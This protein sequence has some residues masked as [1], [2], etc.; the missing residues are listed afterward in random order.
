MEKKQK[1]LIS[2]LLLVVGVIF[3]LIAGGI[4]VTTAWEYLPLF[5]KQLALL[6]VAGV[7]FGGSYGLSKNEKLGWI[8]D[9]LFHLGNAFIGFFIIAIMGGVVQNGLVGN[10]FKVFAASGAMAIPVGVKM[11]NNKSPFDYVA[12]SILVDSML[13]SGCVA[14]KTTYGIYL[15]LLAAF[16][17]TLTVVDCMAQ[18]RKTWENSF[19]ICV[20]VVNLVHTIGFALLSAVYVLGVGWESIVAIIL[21]ATT[22]LTTGLSWMVRKNVAFRIW[23]S[24]TLMY[25]MFATMFTFVNLM[26]WN[27]CQ[28]GELVIATVFAT[29]LMVALRR[30]EMI[31]ITIA[32]AVL[33]PYG[34]LLCYFFDAWSWWDGADATWT[35]MYNPYSVIIGVGILALYI[36]MYGLEDMLVNWKESRLLTF[37]G[38]QMLNGIV[39][40]TCS[41]ATDFWGMAFFLLVTVDWLLVAMLFKNKIARN[42][43]NTFAM[44][45]FILAIMNQPFV[46]VKDN[47]LVEW[48]CF[49]FGIMI[50]LFRYIWYDKKDK[51]SMV[52]FVATCLILITLLLHNLISGELGNVMILGM[53]GI[54]MLVVSAMKNDK[55]YVVASSTTLILLVLYL[56]REFWLSIAWWV[57]LFAAGVGLVLLAVKKAKEV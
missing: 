30:K 28:G 53:I 31:G 9:T 54:V 23:N 39:L 33:I 46:E 22:V 49:L 38:A 18:I 35:T 24:V 26:E 25:T 32:A 47:Y 7:M 36:L 17:V 2:I 50:V 27:D 12:L 52:Y 42:V 43:F 45:T 3:I 41:K 10:A 40:W 57:Y 6:V 51:L 29:I 34:Q 1:S 13:L 14:S 56:T 16:T 19:E 55:R 48:Y 5:V 11:I 20:C 8:S 37:A 4:F 21:P 15:C 44:V